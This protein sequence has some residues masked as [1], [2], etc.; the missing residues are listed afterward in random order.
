MSKAR[1]NMP[2]FKNDSLKEIFY[3]DPKDSAEAYCEKIGPKQSIIRINLKRPIT[4]EKC[5]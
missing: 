5:Q 1:E 3:R 4:A 2:E